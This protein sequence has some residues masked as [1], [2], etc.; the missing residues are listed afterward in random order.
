MN[1]SR[2][3]RLPVHV[4]KDMNVVL[5]AR[6]HL[7]AHA[8]KPAGAEDIAHLCGKPVEEVRRMLRLAEHTASLD[9]P[10]GIDPD[11]SIGVSIAEEG[12]SP[13]A[14]LA[15]HELEAL[16]QAWL[17]QLSDKQRMVIERR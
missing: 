3:I 11:L 15:S 9:A 13:D 14:L 17:A 4:V 7:E 16:V 12:P 1:Q 6:R 2:T 10:L 8:E 5:R